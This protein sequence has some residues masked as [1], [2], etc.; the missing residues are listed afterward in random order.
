VNGPRQQCGN[1]QT[2]FDYVLADRVGAASLLAV[3]IS[4]A[5][6]PST[7]L[8]LTAHRFAISL[9]NHCDHVAFSSPIGGDAPPT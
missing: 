9:L 4:P 2:K 5:A 3:T 7:V 1:Q 8:S 6:M